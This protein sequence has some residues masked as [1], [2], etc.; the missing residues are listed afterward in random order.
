MAAPG[1]PLFDPDEEG[2]RT[3]PEWAAL[4]PHYDWA[5]TAMAYAKQTGESRI[6]FR[7]TLIVMRYDEFTRVYTM[8]EV[9]L[10]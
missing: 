2:H 5:L 1:P 7:S 9:T 6:L 8:Y 4:P 3:Q 10:L